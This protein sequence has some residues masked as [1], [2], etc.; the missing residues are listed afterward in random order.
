MDRDPSGIRPL[1]L[2]VAAARLM[3]DVAAVRYF[4]RQNFLR[5]ATADPPTVHA[6][7]VERLGRVLARKAGEG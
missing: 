4:V 1:P 6:A 3:V 2:D 7:D 5:L